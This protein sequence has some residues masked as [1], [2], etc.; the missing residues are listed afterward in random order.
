MQG[1]QFLLQTPGDITGTGVRKFITL[2]VGTQKVHG[3]VRGNKQISIEN[4]DGLKTAARQ[5]LRKH[6]TSHLLRE[7]MVPAGATGRHHL[8]LFP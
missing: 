7:V 2:P 6:I 4:A 8:H 1:L 3:R 5:M